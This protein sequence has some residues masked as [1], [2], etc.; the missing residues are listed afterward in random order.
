MK[1]YHVQMRTDELLP[2]GRGLALWRWGKAVALQDVAYGLVTEGVPEVGQGT[3]NAIIP[4][5][6]ILLRHA[7]HQVLHFLVDR[8][9]SRTLTLLGAVTFLRDEFAV[10]RE[11]GVGFDDGGHFLQDL[12]A[13]LL[14]N[15]GQRLALA[16]TQLDASRDLIAEHAVFGHQV[17]IA[18]QEFLIDGP[19][20][21]RQQVF[22]IHRL[23]PQPLPSLLTRSRG[24]GGAEDKP[25]HARWSKR[26]LMW[27]GK[28]EYFD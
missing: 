24:Y 18:H 1:L 17:L 4:P 14:A 10:P 6:T 15:L 16:I 5:G 7:H 28:F 23:P 26:N 2:R 21:R 3:D 11:D 12:L 19:R 13:V 25:K 20:D 22:P 8:R 27:E 9:A